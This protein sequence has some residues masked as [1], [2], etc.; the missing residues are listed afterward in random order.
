MSSS[1]DNVADD[2]CT[3]IYSHNDTYH[4][5]TESMIF[6]AVQCPEGLVYKE[7]GNNCG[8][9]CDLN[10]D[11]IDCREECIAGCQCPDVSINFII[12]PV[13]S[14]CIFFANNRRPPLIFIVNL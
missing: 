9:N 1:V 13:I 8:L 10:E 7:C 2:T 5:F 6:A 4:V 14:L 12:E 3:R 11:P